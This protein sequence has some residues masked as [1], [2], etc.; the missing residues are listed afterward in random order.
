MP[1]PEE[2]LEWRQAEGAWDRGDRDEARRLFA[3][4]VDSISNS[5]QALP[6][7]HYLSLWAYLEATAG[8]RDRFE[9]L[10]Q[11]AFSLDPNAPLL[12]LSYARVLWT[13][14][15]D[16]SACASA[17]E[18]L[19]EL[20]ASDRWDRTIDLAPLAYEQKVSTLRAWLRGEP[21]GPLWP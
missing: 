9:S 2:P 16:G 10:Y 8:E 1:R 7:S 12:R 6:P 4:V 19:E 15:K 13:E 14:F 5:D 3:M 11:H 21:G 20:L 18:E 17:I